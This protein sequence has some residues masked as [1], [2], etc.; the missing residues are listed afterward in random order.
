M[1][2]EEP[3]APRTDTAVSPVIR[4]EPVDIP[5]PVWGALVQ[6]DLRQIEEAE[7]ADP[8]AEGTLHPRP[9]RLLGWLSLLMFA[10]TAVLHGLA[11]SAAAY[12]DPALGVALAWCAISAS[13]A[14]V[15]LGVVAAAL[16]RGRWLGV[17]G[18]VGGLLAN[19]WVV[20]QVL[21]LFSA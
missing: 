3:A 6:E 16:G 10:V 19:P 21:R 11:V 9:R 15:V 7:A 17:V 18:A 13:V 5:T 4:G 12:A 2:T 1:E 14:A 20:L 8:G